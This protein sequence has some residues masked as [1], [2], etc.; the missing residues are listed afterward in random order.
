M[1]GWRARLGEGL[2][3]VARWGR[4]LPG[5]ARVLG[6]ELASQ[7]VARRR[8]WVVLASVLVCAYA[9]GVLGY[10]LFTPEIGIRCAFTPVVN[11]FYPEFL[12][13]PGQE[14]L[15]PGDRVVRVADQPVENWS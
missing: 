13:P 8:A 7:P 5:Q 14:P 1:A 11:H 4:A 2:G 10:V 15:R 6:A 3:A 9:G 12:D